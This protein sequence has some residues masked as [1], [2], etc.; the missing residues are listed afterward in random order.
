MDLQI[1]LLLC[2]IF[3]DFLEVNIDLRKRLRFGI[4]RVYFSL[5][6]PSLFHNFK[7]NGTILS[8]WV[9]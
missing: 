2:G 6:I 4:K 9:R 3:Y 5:L 7:L 1:Q 8:C